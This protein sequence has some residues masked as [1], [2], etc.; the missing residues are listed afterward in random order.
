[1]NRKKIENLLVLL[2]VAMVTSIV[3]FM[4][5]ISPQIKQL[6]AMR[7]QCVSQKSLVKKRDVM[8]R[9]MDE[10]RE[11]A[12]AWKKKANRM[13][14]KFLKK[15]ELP[16]FFKDLN[17]I[18]ADTDVVLKTVDP[19][20]KK[21]DLGQGVSIMTIEVDVEGK[22]VNIVRFIAELLGGSGLINIDELVM[23]VM[24]DGKIDASFVLKIFVLG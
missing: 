23:D 2:L 6:K 20:E 15:E 18:T 22:Y 4:L 16:I 21:E 3:F 14:R 7:R 1:M 11:S 24:V 8:M 9:G 10:S 17:K 13:E 5:F 12:G 19:S